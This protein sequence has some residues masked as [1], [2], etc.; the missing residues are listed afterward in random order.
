MSR[1]NRLILDSQI[2]YI[3]IC[4][5]GTQTVNIWGLSLTTTRAHKTKLP[6]DKTPFKQITPCRVICKGAAQIKTVNQFCLIECQSERQLISPLCIIISDV[7]KY[8]CLSSAV[9]LFDY[10]T[11][12]NANNR[13]LILS[14]QDQVTLA[15]SNIILFNNALTDTKKQPRRIP[16]GPFV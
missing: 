16:S 7:V 12:E 15:V 4:I 8:S 13:Q 2:A 5:W 14:D 10:R 11:M 1:W 3:G 6:L 9:C